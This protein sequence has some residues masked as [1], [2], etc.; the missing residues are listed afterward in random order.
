MS[1]QT[2]YKAPYIIAVCALLCA[3]GT[4]AKDTLDEIVVTARRLA[5]SLQE[6]PVSVTAL[7]ADALAIAGAVNVTDVERLAPNVSFTPGTGGGSGTVNA[8][9]RGAGEFDFI[10][11]TDPAVGT[12]IDG[13]YLAR[14]FGANLELAD[15]ERVEVLRGPQGTLFGKNSIGGAINVATKKPGTESEGS[16]EAEVGSFAYK[17]INLYAS[18]PLTDSLAVS[19]S[20]LSRHADGW[21]KRPG[22]DA[23]D[24]DVM[25]GR[26]QIRYTPTKDF[27]SLLVFDGS[28]KRQAGYPNVMHTYTPNPFT[29]FPLDLFS[30]DC[31]FPNQ[32]ID[33]SQAG[34]SLPNDNLEAYGV[35]WTNEVNMGDFNLKS[36][37]AYRTMNA[38]FGRDGDNSQDVL[39]GD[40]HDEDHQQISQEFQFSGAAFDGKLDWLAGL[41]YFKEDSRDDTDL[42][43][44]PGLL[45]PGFELSPNYYNVQETTNYSAYLHGTWHFSERWGLIAGLR[46]TDEEKDFRQTITN[47]F[48][49]TPWVAVD[50][51]FNPTIAPGFAT[52]EPACSDIDSSL[53]RY[54]CSE[55]WQEFSPKLGLEYQHSDSLMIYGHW[56]QGFRSG[57]FNGRPFG[58]VNDI[59]VYDPETLDS[60]E[61][62][63]K[64]EWWGRRLR[65]NGAA[66]YNDYTDIQVLVIQAGAVAIEN[67]SKATVQGF[68]LE[69]TL[70]PVADLEINLGIGF[71]EDDSEGWV[72]ITGDHTDTE[73]QNTPEWSVNA[74]VSY[75][76]Q[77]SDI[78]SLRFSADMKYKDEYYLDAVN[79]E[80]LRQ[81]G[82][83]LYNAGIT[84]TT[85]KRDW[86]VALRGENL[87]DKRAKIGGF[88]GVGFFGYTEA[89]YNPPR[90]WY[91]SARWRY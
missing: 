53:T 54:T 43:I 19:F 36:I 77:M 20:G 55:D 88:D 87:G 69:A 13:V 90:L 8:F 84:Y 72:D 91:L 80:A 38:L 7:S 12:Y 25:S 66:Y 78:G 41:Y 57:G 28:R 17:G 30:P 31:C 61:I 56:S 24:I 70:L 63:F 86:E 50:A 6:A 76:L 71:I 46:W 48:L 10:I 58:S 65:L 23:G 34:G 33:K 39:N 29:A 32:D 11:T 15:V 52:P 22:A 1:N 3:D 74:A 59:R 9:I 62:G 60:Y 67:A 26:L 14:A 35:N 5:E 44:L 45:G 37:T 68:E 21:Q 42:I 16:I 47:I 64:S 82:Y 75:E 83:T 40:V 2:L 18:Q 27:E 89:S 73:L 49:G 4:A 51:M 85:P 79:T 81:G